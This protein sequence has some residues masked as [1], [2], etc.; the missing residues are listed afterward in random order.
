[1]AKQFATFA[2]DKLRWSTRLPSPDVFTAMAW[3][4]WT[5]GS[6]NFRPWFYRYNNPDHPFLFSGLNASA[7]LHTNWTTFSTDTHVGTV[8]ST[9]LNLGTWYHCAISVSNAGAT[10]SV[11]S[12]G[13]LVG[14]DTNTG[15]TRVTTNDTL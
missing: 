11:Y 1:M 7:Q 4:K 9:A 12:N 3:V 6:A 13:S 15:S 2:A 5:A 8:D 14:T 10:I